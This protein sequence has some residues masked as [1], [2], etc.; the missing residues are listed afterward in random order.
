MGGA[1]PAE[2][3]ALDG[4]PQTA[5]QVVVA[6]QDKGKRAAAPDSESQEHAQFLEGGRGV[7][8]GV[9]EDEHESAGFDVGEVF[10]EGEQVGAAFEPGT[11]AELG[12]QDFEDAGGRECR[13]GDE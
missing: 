5:E 8:L 10:F 9:V 1:D 6:K 4:E 2:Q 13:L 3:G 7:I 12:E 11:F